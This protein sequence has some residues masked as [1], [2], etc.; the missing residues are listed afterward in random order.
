MNKIG[1]KR[2]KTLKSSPAKLQDCLSKHLFNTLTVPTLTYGI[3]LCDLTP[4]LVNKLPLEKKGS[5]FCCLFRCSDAQKL[6]MYTSILM[7]S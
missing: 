2:A 4:Q 7:L 5:V 6:Q 3:E 1:Q